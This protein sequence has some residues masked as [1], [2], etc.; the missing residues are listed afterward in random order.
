MSNQASGLGCGLS[1]NVAVLSGQTSDQNSGLSN[2]V[3]S[4]SSTLAVHANSD[5]TSD[6]TIH[7]KPGDV[8]NLT[9]NQDNE[10][11]D[12]RTSEESDEGCSQNSNSGAMGL[13]GTLMALLSKFF[14]ND[15]EKEGAESDESILDKIEHVFDQKPSYKASAAHRKTMNEGTIM[16][17]NTFANDPKVFQKYGVITPEKLKQIAL[18]ETMSSGT[19]SAADYLSK[20][21]KE[22]AKIETADVAGKDGLAGKS[23]FTAF[24]RKAEAKASPG[25]ASKTGASSGQQTITLTIQDS[26]VA[27]KPKMSKTLAAHVKNTLSDVT[28]MASNT[29]ANDSKMFAKY[30]VTTS[31]NLR[32]IAG[33]SEM[34]LATRSAAQYFIDHPGEYAKVET[35]DVKGKDGI[36]GKTAYDAYDRSPAAVKGTAAAAA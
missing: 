28:S 6:I 26:P 34:S 14:S 17:S 22:Y 25:N 24:N 20:H 30:H 3:C 2:G 19:R 8:I 31:K 10:I 27:S 29:M 33:D 13:L 7:A 32:D 21:P 9:V 15:E 23:A 11:G 1:S 35:A 4:S 12:Q 5:G 18:D 16:A 36:A